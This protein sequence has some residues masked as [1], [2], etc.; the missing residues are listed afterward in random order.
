MFIR[1]YSD[2]MEDT[3]SAQSL[4]H[5]LLDW[6]DRH[7][8]VMP[9]RA[10]PGQTPDPYH[11]W[12]SE[13]M[14]QQT[15]VTAVKPYFERFIDRWPAVEHLADAETD[16]VMQMW[17][18]LG[19]YARARNLHKCAKAV[20][21]EYNGVFPADHDALLRLPGIGPY[22]A[23][24]IASI[25]FNQDYTAVDG[26]VERVITR[27]YALEKPLAD[28]KADIK[29]RAEN[30][31]RGNPRPSDFTQ[32]FMELGATI[33]TPKSPKCILCPWQSDCQ[34]LEK[35]IASDLPIRKKKSAKPKRGG[36][37]YWIT[38]KKGRVMVRK[39]PNKGLLGGMMEFPSQGWDGDADVFDLS[40]GFTP[41]EKVKE[42]VKHVFTHFEL[43]LKIEK[44]QYAGGNSNDAYQWYNIEDL[45]NLALPSVMKKVLK[46][47]V[48]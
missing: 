7:R 31:G 35:G 43:T 10:M 8:R 23:A 18:G 37:V 44:Y 3:R 21:S 24:A 38:D 39:R 11:V 36:V 30:L 9:W 28:I 4:Q 5:K 29:K 42:P 27:F 46:L 1:F 26:N 33:C 48:Y 13:I 12:L 20:V 17:A 25:A 14:L 45:D 41:L 34:A 47:S 16:D 6:Y 32:A 19:Y 22:T 15:T 40:K 2:P